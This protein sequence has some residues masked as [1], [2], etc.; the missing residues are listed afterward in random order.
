MK[1]QETTDSLNSNAGMETSAPLIALSITLCY[2]PTHAS[3]RCCLKSF[4]SCAFC[5]R[6]AASDF[7]MKCIEARTVRW[8]E[9]WNF[10]GCLTLLHF[11]TGGSEWCTKCQDRH[12]W[13]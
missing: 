9:V 5:G 12:S 2:T 8:P 1:C 6:L 4:T 7:V 10:Y 13:L 3:N 11:W